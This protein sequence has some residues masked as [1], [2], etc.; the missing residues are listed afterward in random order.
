MKSSDLIKE[1][2]AK[3]KEKPQEKKSLTLRN[4]PK[5]S[6][7]LFYLDQLGSSHLVHISKAEQLLI[8]S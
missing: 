5:Q 4:K 2:E 1:N 8:L 6:P 3:K 7:T